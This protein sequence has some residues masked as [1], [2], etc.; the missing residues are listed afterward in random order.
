MV[1][2]RQHVTWGVTVLIVGA[3]MLGVR[4]FWHRARP[5]H[6]RLAWRRPISHD[7]AGII[8]HHSDTPGVIHGKYVGA[9]LIDRSHKR[10]GF[11]T[12]Y[13]GKFYHIGYH[14]VIREDGVIE[15]GR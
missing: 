9:A 14:Y 5:I 3:A 2:R 6:P 12:H 8:I 10:R 15:P 11:S 4:A 13:R 1:S 7:P